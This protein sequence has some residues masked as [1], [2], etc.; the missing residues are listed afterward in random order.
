MLRVKILFAKLGAWL[1]LRCG[2]Y[3]LWSRLLRA[4]PPR[5]RYR[6]HV[7]ALHTV[8]QILSVFRARTWTPDRWYELGD[9]INWP[10]AFEAHSGDCDEYA[11][12]ALDA[13]RD[14]LRDP[15]ERPLV[16]VGLLTTSY[17]RRGKI[18]G[19]NVAL[20]SLPSGALVHLSNWGYYDQG[21][22]GF[23]T[24]EAC[25]LDVASRIR[26]LPVA[27]A[28]VTAELDR[29]LLYRSLEAKGP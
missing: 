26:A 14:G 18:A 23:P 3:Y 21:G 17:I 13:G 27:F 28:V 12:Y 1:M 25:A 4:L 29:L 5:R 7:L 15:L 6:G 10:R 22:S 8:D 19:H 2:V 11:V 16:P 24:C 9:S 20:F